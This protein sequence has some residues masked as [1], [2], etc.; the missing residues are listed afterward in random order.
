M[1]NVHSTIA[2]AQ[3]WLIGQVINDVLRDRCPFSWWPRTLLAKH[4]SNAVAW[5]LFETRFYIRSEH[6]LVWKRM[7]KI[8]CLINKC[9]D[10]MKISSLHNV[11]QTFDPLQHQKAQWSRGMILALGARGPGF[12]SRLS[13]NIFFLFFNFI[14]KGFEIWNSISANEQGEE[15][16][17]L[18]DLS[19]CG[20]NCVKQ[21]L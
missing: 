13:P 2:I 15:R 9:L 3:A 4:S 19:S 14:R 16:D 17:L 10:G 6:Q 8:N 12:N 1:Q 21:Q 7:K 11:I 18:T 20:D 5:T